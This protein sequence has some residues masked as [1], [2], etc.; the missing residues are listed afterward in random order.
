MVKGLSALLVAFLVIVTFPL[1]IALIAG[2]FGIVIGICG[3]I[4]GVF[5]GIFGAIVGIIGAIIDLI[6]GG[7]F[8]WNWHGPHLFHNFHLNGFAVTAIIIVLALLFRNKSK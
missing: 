1:W 2:G 4:F 8:D 6:F 5:A 3:A 7:I